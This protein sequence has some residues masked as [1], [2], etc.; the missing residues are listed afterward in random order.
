M[1]IEKKRGC[2][3]RKVGGLYLVGSGIAVACDRLPYE[4]TICPTCNQGIKFTQGFTWVDGL[5][6]FGKHEKWELE[7]K[8]ATD[9]DTINVPCGDIDPICNPERKYGLMWVGEKFY[10]TENFIK[11]AREMGISKRIAHV[12]RGLKIG[13]FILLAHK[14]AVTKTV[15]WQNNAKCRSCRGIGAKY[16]LFR[17]KAS[18]ELC[19]DRSHTEVRVQ[20]IFYGFHLTAIEKII[21]ESQSENK[22]LMKEL[23]GN[24]IKPVIVPDSDKDHK[25]TV[26]D[27]LREKT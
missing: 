12:P 5:K 27:D 25:G 10:T 19:A 9:E 8:S 11:E 15:A 24:N 20:G 26:Y 18:K 21:T 17:P 1:A 2:G 6:F 13:D 23:E 22:E 14:K 3:Y 4:L 16:G 7:N